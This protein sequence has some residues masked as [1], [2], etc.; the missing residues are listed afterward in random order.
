MGQKH[1]EADMLPTDPGAACAS[2]VLSGSVLGLP[3]PA[4][5]P[6]NA[7]SVIQVQAPPLLPLGSSEASHHLVP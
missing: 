5:Q 4:P 3:P 1:R 6:I 7:S 2:P